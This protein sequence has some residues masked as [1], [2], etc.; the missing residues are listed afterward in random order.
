MALIFW[1]QHGASTSNTGLAGLLAILGVLPVSAS[2][3]LYVKNL[4]P[5]AGLIGL[6]SQRD[7][8]TTPSGQMAAALYAVLLM[9][10]STRA[11]TLNFS[12]WMG[13]PC[14]S[15][16]SCVMGWRKTGTTVRRALVATEWW[17]A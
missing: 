16:L 14:V 15:P 4:S 6:P 17:R 7:A 8:Q 5:V 13:R 3:P 10:M 2:E 11:A 9:I 1:A 12:I